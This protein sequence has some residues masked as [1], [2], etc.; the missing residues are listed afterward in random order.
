MLKMLK[1]YYS[2]MNVS[3]KVVIE[4]LDSSKTPKAI[5][6]Y[7]KGTRIDMGTLNMIFCSGS[8]GLDPTSGELVSQDVGEQTVQALENMKNLLEYIINITLQ[9][10]RWLAREHC[11]DYHLLIGNLKFLTT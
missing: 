5:G 4:S 7:S 8:I 1:K 11:Q 9:G 10:E 6:P 3:N 2:K